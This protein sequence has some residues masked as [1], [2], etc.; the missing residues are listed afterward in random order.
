MWWKTCHEGVD[1]SGCRLVDSD[2]RRSGHCRCRVIRKAVAASHRVDGRKGFVEG[3]LERSDYL[4]DRALRD[5]RC[6]ARGALAANL[7]VEEGSTVSVEV[8]KTAFFAGGGCRVD[9]RY[10]TRGGIAQEQMGFKRISGQLTVWSGEFSRTLEVETYEDRCE[11]SDE[12]FSVELT[13]GKAT[14]F[15]HAANYGLTCSNED[16][17]SA[18]SIRIAIKDVPSESGSSSS[19]EDQKHVC[20]GGDDSVQTFGE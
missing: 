2:T 4:C 16:V 1:L 20:G 17:P 9:Y 19:Y 12:T 18:I 8:S 3:S 10:Q 7:E 6:S 15:G 11:E 13:G 14:A 5:G